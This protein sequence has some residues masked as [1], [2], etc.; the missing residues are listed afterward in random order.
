[1]TTKHK[2]FY[3]Q[4]HKPLLA[5]ALAVAGIF[6]MVGAVLA[7]GTAAGTDISNTATAT[8]KDGKGSNFDATSNTVVIKVAEIAGLIA[9]AS[10][11]ED[12][13]GGAI[14]AGD[15]L[16][17][18]FTITNVGN[19]S[20][21]VFIP[22]ITGFTTENFTPSP[23][24]PVKVFAADGTTP[25]GIVQPG[26]S[27]IIGLGGTAIQPDKS[28]VVKVTGTPASGARAGDT[29]SVTIGNTSDNTPPEGA[30]PTQNQPDASDGGLKANDLRTVNV[31][32]SDAPQNGE[33]EAQATGS[34]IFASSVQPLALATVLK[35]SSLTNVGN[36]ANSADDLI[37]YD[38]GLQV[39]NNSPSSLFQA[40]ALEGTNI[41]LDGN[42]AAKRILVSDAI[43]V[44]TKLSSVSTS[45][46]TGWRA[47][48]S[49]ETGNNPLT[50][51]WTTIAPTNL[52]TV[53]R[54]GF[55]NNGPI[56]ATGA[57]IN[58]LKF[59]VVT[60]GVAPTGGLVENIAQ[61]FGQTFGDPDPTPQ[62]IYDESG[63]QNPN[64][65]NDDDSLP[66]AGVG[67]DASGSEYTPGTD[68]G[69][70]VS[71][72][73]G[74]DTNNDN[75]GTGEKGEV[76]VVLLTPTT[77]DILNGTQ[78]KPNAVGPTNDND[79]FTNKSTPTPAGTNPA[80]LFD[81][82]AVTFDNSLSNPAAA[83]FIAATTVEPISPSKAVLAGGTAGAYG[84]DND[85]P[86]GTEVTITNPANGDS[87]IYIYTNADGFKIVSGN[88]PVNFGKVAA[89]SEVDYKV[90]VNLP[91]G[92]AQLKGVSIPLIAFP[93]DD[94][95][96]TP[97]YTGETTNNITIDRLYTGFM[98]LL[99][100][101]RILDK[102]GTDV[103]E[104]FTSTPAQ[105]AAPGQFIEYRISY[106]NITE[107]AAG[108][109]G[110]VGL[111]ANDFTIF[112]AGSTAN[113]NWASVTTHQQN[114]VKTKGSVEYFSNNASIGTTDPASGTVVDEYRNNVGAVAPS[115]TGA[116]TFRRM[117]D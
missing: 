92:T 110:S 55:V 71:T 117:V 102:N 72:V 35:T 96:G 14:E 12:V 115:S 103:V 61:V 80:T 22:N 25:I 30:D 45:L 47:V 107:S 20:T 46:P 62:I 40:A 28:F 82:D 57:P 59:T 11:V 99:K 53:T 1:M 54:V 104:D 13:D 8:Y 95:N 32:G 44:G 74:T 85:I 6:N 49:I 7:E 19:A 69:I 105:K 24:A 42:A 111:T 43:P 88:K 5:T 31:V 93:D 33:R 36:P 86:D 81:P 101:A 17:Y 112:E 66:D 50:L 79:D 108:A 41:K 76:N 70:A 106:K 97:G 34:G 90:T 68:T 39:E 18:T 89:G 83:G 51:A 87:A 109:A 60:S 52:N 116:F 26:G 114:T 91:A 73:E 4:A 23:T 56:G 9:V 58:G 67:G 16:I 65:F 21:D 84:A 15:D 100:E 63:D 2:R 75:T 48:Y 64:N 27:T 113:N 3:W 78:D 94:P 77:D 98:S 10:P 38:L 29:V 37:T